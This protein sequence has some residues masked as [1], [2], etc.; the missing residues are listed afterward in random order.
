[1][2]RRILTFLLIFLIL[3]TVYS[4]VLYF[5][6]LHHD[7]SLFWLNLFSYKQDLADH[8]IIIGRY[9][10]AWLLNL[11]GLFVHHV[12]DLKFLR[13]LAILLLS[14]FAVMLMGQLRRF[15]WSYIDAFLAVLAVC[16]LPGLADGV[17]YTSNVYVLCSV[18]LACW[19]FC[20][21]MDAKGFL[22]PSLALL[23]A[24]T[25]YPSGAMFYW[26]MVGMFLLFARDRETRD[27]RAELFRLMA[28]GFTS[29]LSYGALLFLMSFHY[30]DKVWNG[31]NPYKVDHDWS[32]KLNWFLHEPLLNALNL[33]NIFP[34]WE[35][36]FIISGFIVLTA[37]MV[38]FR[39]SILLTSL[40]QIALLIF[41]LF[42]S[43]LPNLA[44]GFNA[45]FYRCLVPLTALIIFILIWAV[46]Q[47]IK[48]IPNNSKGGLI[49]T[50][51]LCVA[52]VY[53]G[54]KTF[55]NVLYFRVLPSHIE[56][57]AFRQMAQSVPFK[58]T[59]S[60]YIICPDHIPEIERYDEFGVLTSQYFEDIYPILESAFKEDEL[61]AVPLPLIYITYP[62]DEK[63]MSITR[64]LTQKLPGGGGMLT[65]IANGEVVYLN[66]FQSRDNIGSIESR[67]E[68]NPGVLW[69]KHHPYVLDLRQIFSVEHYGRLIRQ[70]LLKFNDPTDYNK[71]GTIEDSH[72][73]YPQAVLNYTKAIALNPNIAEFYL[74][75][76]NANNKQGKLWQAL[77]DYDKAISL[78]P[79][80]TAAYM[81]LAVT[82]YQ[83][84]EF[85]RSWVSLRKV[86]ELG[87]NFMALRKALEKETG[88]Q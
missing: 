70:N 20:K 22:I 65:N 54:Y 61:G 80:Y 31:Y 79:D 21:A 27:F 82:Y 71:R 46:I 3:G 7:E 67:V 53:G 74:N 78:K 86:E 73:N 6:F 43:F 15:S 36:A 83:L 60:I 10:S 45:P 56:W 68:V 48:L 55:N 41:I 32:G 26:T 87:G 9:A 62:Q 58:K 34:R 50:I 84:K 51:L 28:I 14:G 69:R 29:L 52:A 59:D 19:S 33:W 39:K 42:L 23:A 38:C 11:Q 44:A 81:D 76:G 1:M 63:V 30:R 8:D 72:G 13:F 16:F 24:I 12:S 49:L 57:D 85:N 37:V 77:E 75:R 4:P 2:S 40:W 5:N 25:F 17:F 64:Y 47:W 35:M 18:T 88:R 66:N